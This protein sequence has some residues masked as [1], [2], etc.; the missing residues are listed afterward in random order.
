MGRHSKTIQIGVSFSPR[1]TFLFRVLCNFDELSQRPCALARSARYRPW[2]E[3]MERTFQLDVLSC[4]RCSGRL[5]LLAP[6]IEPKEIRRYLRGLGNR[7][8]HPREV[9][10]AGQS[11]GVRTRFVAVQAMLTRPERQRAVDRQRVV[12]ER[13]ADVHRP[14][15][16]SGFQPLC[17]ASRRPPGTHESLPTGTLG[18]T[19]HMRDDREARS[20]CLRSRVM[21]RVASSSTP[22]T[23]SVVS[24]GNA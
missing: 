20:I 13:A 24:R 10:H 6:M 4:P 1:R 2:A 9:R 14:R 23:S 22:A 19:A 11:T 21:R 3:L 16:S 12:R 8:S 15:G 5:R 17:R 7:P 18:T